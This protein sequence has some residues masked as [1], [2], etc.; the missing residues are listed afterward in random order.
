MTIDTHVHYWQFDPVRDAWITEAMAVLRQDYLPQQA[1]S[2]FTENAVDACIAVQADQSETET[3][4][5][6]ELAVQN[7]FIK[8]L[9]G[10]VDLSSDSIEERLAYYSRFPIIK[11]WRHIV[12]AEPMDFLQR[13]DFRRGIKALQAYAYTYDVLVY[14]Q[15]LKPALAFMHAFPDQRFIIDH[16]AKPAIAKK[17]IGEWAKYMKEMAQHPDVYCKLSG[18]LTEAAW[19]DWT[20]ADFYP[21][22]DTV[23]DCFGTERLLFGSDWPVMLLSG[24][25][26]QWKSLLETYMKNCSDTERQNIFGANAVRCYNL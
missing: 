15:Q 18:L 16:C 3:D 10:W 2:V 4:F 17:E 22:L 11:G 19:N 1:K 12:Q 5:L 7:P 23:F 24:T 20:P 9:V 14:H 13:E 6:V 8:G 26:R 25:Y 21:Y